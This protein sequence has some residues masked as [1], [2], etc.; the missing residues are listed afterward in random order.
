MMLSK[1]VGQ[2][3]PDRIK[4]QHSFCENLLQIKEHAIIIHI[5]YNESTEEETF[6]TEYRLKTEQT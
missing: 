5:L 2:S 6:S 3:F 4:V 1:Q